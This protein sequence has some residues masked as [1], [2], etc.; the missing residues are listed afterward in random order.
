LTLGENL[1]YYR[2]DKKGFKDSRVQGFKKVVMSIKYDDVYKYYD[3]DIK[4]PKEFQYSSK[5]NVLD[6]HY[7]RDYYINRISKEHLEHLSA[8]GDKYKDDS[9]KASWIGGLIKPINPAEL[10]SAS[11]SSQSQ[12][13][14][15]N[16][17]PTPAIVEDTEPGW[18][19]ACLG[20][21]VH[22]VV[23]EG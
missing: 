9:F 4:I 19:S 16:L 21:L 7:S 22:G 12:Y 15:P 10:I 11:A 17:I 8:E 2:G 18:D 13:I 1:V 6:I 23:N 5:E 20:D 14:P 3:Y